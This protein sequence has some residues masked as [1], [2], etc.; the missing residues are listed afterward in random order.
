MT[1]NPNA[2]IQPATMPVVAFILAVLGLCFFPLLPVA[3][4]LA[5]ISLARSSQP[6]YAQRTALA[7]VALVTPLVFVAVA[8]I[9][10]AIAIPNF[11]R[12]QAR[13]KQA[14]CR[15]NLKAALAAEEAFKLE[16]DAYT[17][18]PAQLG[19]APEGTR[20]ILRFASTGPL[21]SVGL[22]P[23]RPGGPSGELLDR[24]IPSDLRAKLGIDGTCPD[25][26]INIA[27][28]NDV[29]NDPTV[30]VWSISSAARDG[31]PAGQ[32]HN[33]VNDVIE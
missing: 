8:G 6:A 9:L 15:V 10:A 12:Y 30:D 1:P 27:C 28:V 20:S 3:M 2:P 17:T 25:C 23:Q 16:H 21:A 13:A 29:D 4:V 31:I 5:I 33:E 26:S 18:S 22:T 19:F 24:G 14:E 11:V 7:I 32:L